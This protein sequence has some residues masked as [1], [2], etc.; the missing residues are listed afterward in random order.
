MSSLHYELAIQEGASG[1]NYEERIKSLKK[2]H[3]EV[4]SEFFDT[5]L[6]I[7][8]VTSSKGH[9][10]SYDGWESRHL[11]IILASLAEV[12]HEIYVVPALRDD[13]RKSVLALKQELLGQ[14]SPQDPEA[15]DEPAA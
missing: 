5:L 8:Q 13:R 12:L 7:Q 14:E 10:N 11:R 9:E 2:L 3:P 1:E 4:A 15:G 6:T